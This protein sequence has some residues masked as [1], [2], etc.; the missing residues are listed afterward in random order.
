MASED[1]NVI[2]LASASS[3]KSGG[4]ARQSQHRHRFWYGLNRNI[5]DQKVGAVSGR[6]SVRERQ[7]SRRT[8]GGKGDRVGVPDGRKIAATG[9]IPER[10]ARKHARVRIGQFNVQLLGATHAKVREGERNRVGRTGRGGEV[11]I[12]PAI[13]RCVAG[14]ERQEATAV[15]RGAVSAR[16]RNVVAVRECVS[17]RTAGGPASSR[18]A[19]SILEA[20][21]HNARMR[22]GDG[23]RNSD[24][25]NKGFHNSQK[26][27][28]NYRSFGVYAGMSQFIVSLFNESC[29][30][31]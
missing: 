6:S 26:W 29:G 12:S 14:V 11:L 19:R 30:A 16:V 15:R 8:G 28:I 27:D 3:Q 18:A 2:L 22:Q 10:V 24:E 13:R 20:T 1:L 5:I 31:T 17:E 4:A 9:R 23:A 25:R 21:I 7:S